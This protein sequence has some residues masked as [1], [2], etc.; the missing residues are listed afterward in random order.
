MEAYS[1]YT[2]DG[3]EARCDSFSDTDCDLNMG[4]SS[5][6]VEPD[7]SEGIRPY[8][9]EPEV[10]SDEDLENDPQPA[11][12][13][14]LG[15]TDWCQ[16]ENCHE[17]PTAT[18]CICCAEILQIQHIRG[19][20]PDLKCITQHPGFAP[21]CLN[22][23]VLRTAYHAFR[24]HHNGNIPESP[25][26]YRYT[27]YRQLVRWCWGFLG[28]NVRVPL[29]ACAVHVIRQTFPCPEG[30]IVTGFNYGDE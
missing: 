28:R 27:A 11:T 10:G 1:D 23:F 2:S 30:E 26:R 15:S 13:D 14:R 12:E 29:P 3:S 24:Q 4:Y 8:Q 6:D 17:M 22:V 19:E 7:H 20:I 21:V 16:C 5:S 18:E 25:A 9:F